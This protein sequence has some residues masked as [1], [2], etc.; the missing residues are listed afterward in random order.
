MVLSFQL[1]GVGDNPDPIRNHRIIGKDE[2]PVG[3]TLSFQ[4]NKLVCRKD[5]QDAVALEL[6]YDAG[7]LGMLNLRTCL[8]PP[9]DKPYLL[10]LELA[11]HRIMLFLNKLESWALSGLSDDTEVMRLFERA[12]D[13]FTRAL[14]GT[15]P[16]PSNGEFTRA[17]ND[18]AHESL[19]LCI[20][21][22]EQLAV[23]NAERMLMRKFDPPKDKQGNIIADK[24]EL[25]PVLVGCSV[26]TAQFAPPLQ[27]I[28]AKHFD[29]VSCPLRWSE[30]EAREG[31]YTFAQTDRWIEWAVRSAKMPVVAGPLLDF[32]RGT[33]PEWLYVWEHDYSTLRE[34][35][36]E[37]MRRVITRYRRTVTRWTVC[38]GLNT[39]DRFKLKIQEMLDLTRLSVL[40][41]RK[42]HPTAEVV[43]EIDQPWGEHVSRNSK[44]LHPMLFADMLNEAGLG[45]DAFGLRIQMGEPREG[46]ATRDLMM[47]S[48]LIDQFTVFGKPLHIS[49]L[50][51][52]SEALE[53]NDTIQI[54]TS[55]GRWHQDQWSGQTQADWLTG[56]LSIALAKPHVK[57]VCW[58]ALYDEHVDIAE[59]PSGGLISA[60]GRAKPSLK[61]MGELLAAFHQE[62]L[63][64]KLIEGASM[65]QAAPSA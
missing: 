40:L 54:P 5:S 57:S 9:R 1:F 25:D 61:R 27:K 55:V 43:V 30:L 62:K 37:H 52:P 16:G 23:L 60:E 19:A 51:S 2:L 47:L 58:Q 49:A 3:V 39:N 15:G 20:E 56:A 41:V 36:Y 64:R 50:G 8:L 35:A 13:E 59:M 63:P 53:V 46:R 24:L 29:F 38:S 14:V 28:V 18:A 11:R 10:T 33:V 31:A 32:S 65:I 17:Q 26:D 22:S 12:R 21:A 34:I 45:I 7:A 4:D 42:L 44:S 48:D 6:Q